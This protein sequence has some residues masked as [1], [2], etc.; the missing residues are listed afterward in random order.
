MRAVSQSFFNAIENSSRD[1]ANVAMRSLSDHFDLGDS[2][3]S[4]FIALI[5]GTLVERG[6]DPLAIAEPLTTKLSAL[7]K[8][9]SALADACVNRMSKVVNQ[10]R[11]PD[12]EFERFRALVAPDMPTEN[13]AWTALQQ[14]WPAAIA[15]YSASAEARGAARSLRD[16]AA[17]ISDYHEAGHWLRLMLSVLDNE[18]LVVIEPAQSLGI[19]GRISGV[20]D[21]FQLNTLLM[22]TF[23]KKGL[24]SR[25]RISQQVAD[26]VRGN[27]P[28]QSDH[29]VTGVWNLY[30]WGAIQPGLTLPSP[31]AYEESTYWIW[32]E[33]TPDDIHLFDGRRAILLGPPSYQGGW[34]AQR[35]FNKLAADLVCER[36]L[37]GDEVGAWLDRMLVAKGATQ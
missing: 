13:D 25:K 24:F 27:G 2:S 21:N 32:N 5:C 4:A 7:L 19:L 34:T 1:E 23:P 35:L 33:G 22:D 26:I 17:A 8:A 10:D 9:S 15:T 12:E 28:Q 6:C 20:V 29:H 11:D 37:T 3:R 16:C 36:E 31:T 14:F 18:P 30:N